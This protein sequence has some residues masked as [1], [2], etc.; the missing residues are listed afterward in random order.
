MLAHDP[1]A[2]SNIGS[3]SRCCNQRAV[4]EQSVHVYHLLHDKYEKFICMILRF[5]RFVKRP[6][7]YHVVALIVNDR[8]THELPSF[9]WASILVQLHPVLRYLRV[10][11]HQMPLTRIMK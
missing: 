8:I 10:S 9:L 11:A 1:F 2:Y 6:P 3:F 5:I 7:Y 4:L